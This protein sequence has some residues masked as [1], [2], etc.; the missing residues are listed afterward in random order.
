MIC[1]GCGRSVAEDALVCDHCGRQLTAPEDCHFS[2]KIETPPPKHPKDHLGHKLLW[3]VPVLLV[4]IVGAVVWL[5]LQAPPAPTTKTLYL[6]TEVIEH[7]FDGAVL[8]SRTMEYDSRGR[9]LKAVEA[10]QVANVNAVRTITYEYDGDRVTKAHIVDGANTFLL[11]YEYKD[12]KLS[13]VETEKSK[14]SAYIRAK[15]DLIGHITR[16]YYFD[17]GSVY[18]KHSYTYHPDGQV[19]TCIVE[20][21]LNSDYKLSYA[22]DTQGNLTEQTFEL[23]GEVRQRITYDYDK[24]NRLT[25]KREFMDLD[26]QLPSN[27][28]ELTYETNAKGQLTA[29]HIFKTEDHHAVSLSLRGKPK[30]RQVELKPVDAPETVPKDLCITVAWDGAGNITEEKVFFGG[31]YAYYRT[32]QYKKVKVPAAYVA[33]AVLE[34]RWFLDI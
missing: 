5:L 17:G 34:P 23:Q 22:Y 16:L 20:P 24:A 13:A 27:T 33:P 7:A 15:C 10:S 32:Y 12:G 18:K 4:A 30:N 9:L 28:L 26:S 21:P 19:A 1:R 6:P 14:N 29:V 8:E 2:Q 11:V 31:N 3:A 25:L